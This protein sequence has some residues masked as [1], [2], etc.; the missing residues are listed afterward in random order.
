MINQQLLDY[1]KQQIQQGTDRE[2][3][4]NSLM[5]N[6]WQAS[7]IKEA[8]DSIMPS[9]QPVQ[10]IPPASSIPQPF[11]TFSPQS[12]NGMSKKLVT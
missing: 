6:G 5:A 2:K 11:S 8:F 7:D 12:Q 1:I 3:I 10:P 9:N 4:N